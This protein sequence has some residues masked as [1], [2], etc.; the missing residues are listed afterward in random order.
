[1]VQPEKFKQN[2]YSK[3]NIFSNLLPSLELSR[4]WPDSRNGPK[5]NSSFHKFTTGIDETV[6]QQ[7]NAITQLLSI[8]RSC[9]YSA[10]PSG[11][12]LSEFHLSN[13]QSGRSSFEIR[14][15]EEQTSLLPRTFV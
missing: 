13:Y 12:I 7:Q 11:T 8:H 15:Q 3:H 1:M 5:Q 4:K 9:F 6:Q 2:H 10:D 14:F